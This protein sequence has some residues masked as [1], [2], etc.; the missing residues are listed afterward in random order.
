MSLDNIM[1]YFEA[2]FEVNGD[3]DEIKSLAKVYEE[4]DVSDAFELYSMVDD[5][6]NMQRIAD[7]HFMNSSFSENKFYEK[8]GV[9]PTKA[10]Y[11]EKAEHHLN[12]AMSTM[13]QAGSHKYSF[14]DFE[15]AVFSYAKANNMDKVN[16]VITKIVNLENISEAYK[17]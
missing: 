2:R 16:E 7:E 9:K 15:T 1:S 17:K 6:E 4:K 11:E 5:K 8:L 12:K 10:M 13:E 14:Y 3:K